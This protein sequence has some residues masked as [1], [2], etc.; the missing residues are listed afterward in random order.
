MGKRWIAATGALVV[1]AGSAVISAPA[2]QAA[3]PTVVRT[4][5]G[6]VAGEKVKLKAVLHLR[7][8]SDNDVHAVDL[9]ATDQTET[10]GFRNRDVDLRKLTLRVKDES[11]KVAA[12]TSTPSSP[13]GVDLGSAGDEVG[14]VHAEARWR[15]HERT[16]VVVCNFTF[17]ESGDGGGTGNS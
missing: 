16:G 2:A 14:K 3:D 4:C 12:K 17:Q 5:T 10:G 9:R 7:S 6:K 1:V 8:A 13:F 15:S 11:G